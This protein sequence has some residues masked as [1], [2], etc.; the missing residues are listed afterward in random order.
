MPVAGVP[1]ILA[2]PSPSSVK[3]KP[4]G[5]V[6]LVIAM[7]GSGCPVVAMSKLSAL[8]TVKVVLSALVMVGATEAG[9]TV[10]VNGCVA[11]GVIPLL[12]V[13]VIG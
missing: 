7:L 1:H 8:P 11:L 3:L 4:V 5:K 9:S 2:V 6:P 10:K 13:M 12:A